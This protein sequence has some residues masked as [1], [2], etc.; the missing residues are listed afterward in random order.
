[1]VQ[2]SKEPVVSERAVSSLQRYMM[3]MERTEVVMRSFGTVINVASSSVRGYSSMLQTSAAQSEALS[4]RTT[5]LAQA[6]EALAQSNEAVAQE[7]QRAASS[8]EGVN[9]AME[10]GA[11]SARNFLSHLEKLKNSKLVQGTK[12]LMDMSDS[13]AQTSTRLDLINSQYGTRL[14][15]EDRIF[16]AAERSRG[17]YQETANL[18]TNL[19]LQAKSAFQGPEEIV[20]FAEQL[21][22]H[23]VLSSTSA[24]QAQGAVK[25]LTAAM[26]SGVLEG[27]AFQTIMTEMPTVAQAIA[28]HMGVTV[29][30]AQALAAQGGIS[31]STVKGAMF[32]MAETVE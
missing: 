1:M 27:A 19:G 6:N 3:F 14:N 24:T 18:V 32:S 10:S 2:L 15:L 30:Q 11:A 25:Q 26:S 8:Q 12:Q 13:F 5:A 4:T 9:R 20:A 28:D 7:T 23:L 17:T 16:A 21:N 22:N 29:E 31:A